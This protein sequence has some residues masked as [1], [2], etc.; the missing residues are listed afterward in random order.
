MKRTRARGR[1]ACCYCLP[2]ASAS[3]TAPWSLPRASTLGCPSLCPCPP[4]TRLF[5]SASFLA[6]TH[7]DSTAV[8]GHTHMHWGAFPRLAIWIFPPSQHGRAPGGRQILPWPTFRV[9]Q[10]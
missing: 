8:Q 7:T 1:D 4:A 10:V 2:W 3:L 9:R 6:R 5:F